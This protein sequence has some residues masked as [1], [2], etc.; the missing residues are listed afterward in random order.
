MLGLILAGG[1]VTVI[2]NYTAVR[3]AIASV[4]AFTGAMV[5]DW[6]VY[7]IFMAKKKFVKMNYS[8]IASGFIDSLLFIWIAFGDPFS[9]FILIQ[10]L[11][12]TL[13]GLLWAYVLIKIIER[14]KR[15]IA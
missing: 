2:F 9:K 4:V 13:G 12:K 15:Q 6:I 14:S 8:N 5:V 3:I 7:E 1:I 11:A 10:F